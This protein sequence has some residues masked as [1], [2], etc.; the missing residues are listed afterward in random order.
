MTLAWRR[1]L[2]AYA[3]MFPALVLTAVFV[4]YPI[5]EAFVVS[6]LHWDMLTAAN[7]AFVGLANYV[8][9]LRD[10]LFYKA[11][12]N[13]VCYVLLFVPCVL[14][15]G[16]AAAVALNARIPGRK[17]M[18][19]L[20]LLP[21]VTSL[22]ATGVLWQWIFNGQFGLLNAL[23]AEFGLPPQNWLF[24]PHLTLLNLLIYGVWQN[25]G[26]VAVILLAGLQNIDRAF[27]EAAAVDGAGAWHKFRHIT[28]PL[29]SPVLWFTWVL[30]TIEAFKVFLQVYVLYSG[31][32]GPNFS[33]ITLLYYMYEQGFSNYRMGEACAAAFILFFI[34]FLVT[35][36]QLVWQRRVH[37]EL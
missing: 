18:R 24:N 13:T 29:L 35:L 4:V 10:P 22:A 5:G 19:A 28:L 32:E 3:M 1:T 23:L 16:L 15:L 21:Y 8:R 12:V 36:V 14:G 26:Y 25:L 11:L 17:V 34:I 31:T 33:G 27:Y 9:I 6:F 30:V 2:S 37:V 20:L 7:R